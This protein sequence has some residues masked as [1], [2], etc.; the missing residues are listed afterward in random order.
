[1]YDYYFVQ[2]TNFSLIDVKKH[3]IRYHETVHERDGINYYCQLKIP[4]K[5]SINLNQ[6]NFKASI[7]PTYDFFY[8][9]CY[10][11]SSTYER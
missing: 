3:W 7:L 4:V 1:M 8:T 10:I 9:M 6:E 5:C 11:T 2:T